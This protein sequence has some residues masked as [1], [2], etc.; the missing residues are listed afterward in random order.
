MLSCRQVTS[1]ASDYV[2]GAL[3][4][5]TRL[6]VRFHL[7]MCWMCRRYLRQLELTTRVLRGLAGGDE[8]AEPPAQVREAFRAW[9]AERGGSDA[10][11]PHR[12]STPR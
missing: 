12:P 2:D 1:L 3:P 10:D 5:R 9:R 11:A 7:L 4:R 8:P 6:G